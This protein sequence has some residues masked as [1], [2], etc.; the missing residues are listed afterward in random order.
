M[1]FTFKWSE[2]E[3]LKKRLEIR[4][5]LNDE[6]PKEPVIYCVF[7]GNECISAELKAGQ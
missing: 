4:A 6:K 1:L 3:A 2:C 5:L 7:R